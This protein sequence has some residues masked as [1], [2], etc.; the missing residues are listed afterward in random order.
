M[1]DDAKLL[2]DVELDP[3]VSG[4]SLPSELGPPH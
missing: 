2:S 3:E 4:L 1:S